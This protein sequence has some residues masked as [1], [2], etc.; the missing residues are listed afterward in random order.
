MATMYEINKNGT[1]QNITEGRDSVYKPQTT[2]KKTMDNS[3]SFL[4]N[5][6]KENNGIKQPSAVTDFAQKWK[7]KNQSVLKY[8][9][10][11]A[12]KSINA[13]LDEVNSF[14]KD[15]DEGTSFEKVQDAS[16]KWKLAN[17][18]NNNKLANS[19]MREMIGHLSKE[20]KEPYL[21]DTQPLQ[22]F[23]DAKDEFDYRNNNYT[24]TENIDTTPDENVRN[25]QNE[26]NEAGYTEKF[27]ERLK[28]DGIYA[29]KTAYAHD[30][31]K[32]DTITN[33]GNV[34]PIHTSEQ[35]KKDTYVETENLS[36]ED[37]LKIA[38]YL[39]Y[40]EDDM[41]VFA[42][43]ITD[44]GE[45]KIPALVAGVNPMAAYK[46]ISANE[47]LNIDKPPS[48]EKLKELKN[49]SR[50]ELYTEIF[51]IFEKKKENATIILH[52][53]EFREIRYRKRT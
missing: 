10:D 4:Y 39:G 46:V 36:K 51:D 40:S 45:I 53:K 16:V 27:G 8:A 44:D 34:N 30:V 29:G 18:A 5:K 21:K 47:I 31:W 50:E 42:I 15:A 9:G 19:A 48:S 41:D 38:E 2:A 7:D 25:L 14:M 32:K 12:K 11:S 1:K 52:C 13:G 28:E 49:M 26:L 3:N 22:T 20:N 24:T 23:I 35:Q 37:W 6:N 43:E 17:D 33:Y